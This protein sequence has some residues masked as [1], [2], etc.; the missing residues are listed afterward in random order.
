M[1][2]H[3]SLCIRGANLDFGT[4][5]GREAEH[6]GLGTGHKR[7]RVGSLCGTGSGARRIGNASNSAAEFTRRTHPCKGD[8][9]KRH[10]IWVSIHCIK[11]RATR[12]HSIHNEESAANSV[13]SSRLSIEF[14]TEQK[15]PVSRS[16]LLWGRS[17]TGALPPPPGGCIFSRTTRSEQ[18]VHLIQDVYRAVA[19]TAVGL[20]DPRADIAHNRTNYCCVRGRYHL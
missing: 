14:A 19:K 7:K 20:A 13:Y 12:P 15:G 16:L 5:Q 4:P 6:P 3:A 8:G 18:R 11:S 10:A 17:Q 9:A 2:R 1:P